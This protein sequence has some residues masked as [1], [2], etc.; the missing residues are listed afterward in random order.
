[1]A[2]GND[3]GKLPNPPTI[4]AE[5]TPLLAE[6]LAAFAEFA[7]DM[8]F[9]A[10]SERLN[11]SQPA[12][13]SKIAKLGRSLDLTLYTND[14][15]VLTLTTEGERLVAYAMD[16]SVLAR[17]AWS[18]LCDAK[19]RPLTVAAGRGSYLYVIP[20]AVKALSTRTGGL[21]LITADNDDAIQSVRRGYVDVATIGHVE[22]PNDVEAAEIGSYPLMLVVDGCHRLASK[23][24]LTVGDL[25][26]LELALPAR[27]VQ[28]R[29][30][31]AST[32]RQ[33]GVTVKVVTEALNWDLLVQFVHFGVEATIVNSFVALHDEQVGIPIGGL[34]PAVYHAIWRKERHQSA[35]EF[36]AHLAL[37]L[38]S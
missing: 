11:I 33:A 22:P 34:P 31:L 14:R 18:D 10:A 2:I 23:K 38:A 3:Y 4:S 28:L 15:N 29:D 12:L 6:P 30:N 9:S 19:S 16:A 7:T 21:R 36:L 1:M 17:S 26:G 13:H 8:N 27:G 24:S 5:L 37:E 20:D 35:E 25:D 32:F